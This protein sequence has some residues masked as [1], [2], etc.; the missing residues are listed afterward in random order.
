M[1][2]CF[3][4]VPVKEHIE[5]IIEIQKRFR[6]YAHILKFVEPQNLHFTVKFLGE[7]STT[8]IEKIKSVLTPLINDQ[9]PF[10]IFLRGIGVFPNRS[11]IRVVWIGVENPEKFVTLAKSID[12]K[13]TGLGFQ[14][15]KGYIPHLTI[16]RVKQRPD[17]HF[18]KLIDELMNIEIGKINVNRLVL[19]ESKLYPSGPVYTELFGW[20]L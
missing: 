7:I 18:V 1:P 6:K 8:T 10:E 16:A 15:E 17:E 12:Q 3:L 2:R 19:Y 20:E 9:E 4:G 5:K 11:F 14:R 13:L